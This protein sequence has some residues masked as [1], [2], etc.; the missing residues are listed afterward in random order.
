VQD[1]YLWIYSPLTLVASRV[2]YKTCGQHKDFFQKTAPVIFNTFQVVDKIFF[3]AY[4][5]AI[6]VSF[7]RLK[8]DT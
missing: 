8:T 1:A 3:A 5:T 6:E 2:I 7:D 4:E